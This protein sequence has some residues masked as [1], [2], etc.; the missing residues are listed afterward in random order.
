MNKDLSVKHSCETRISGWCRHRSLTALTQDRIPTP[1]GREIW[2][3][4]TVK[5]ILTN[6]VYKGDYLYQKYFMLDTLEEK[7]AT[8]QGE[9]PQYYID[10]HHE[11]IIDAEEWE[12][13]QA[14]I[15]E[16][17][18]A[19]KTRNHKKYSKNNNKNEAFIDKL[20]CGECGNG[21][22]HQRTVE[23]RGDD[24]G[25]EVHRW[26]CRLAQKYYAVDGCSSHRFQQAYLEQHFIN[27]LKD[28]HQNEG[29]QAEVNKV[30]ARTELSTQELNLEEEVRKR[31][32][33]LNQALYEAVDEELHQ[34]GQDSKRVDDLSGELVAL[35]KQLKVF[36]DRKKLA[37]QYKNE[38]KVLMK[39]VK[40]MHEEQQLVFPAE[41]YSQLVEQAT[42][43][44]DGKVVYHLSMEIDWSTDERYESSYRHQ[45]LEEKKA[46][47][48]AKR[49]EKQAEFL[50]GPEVTALL[51]YCEKPRR[52]GEILDFMNTMM[53]ISGS[54]FRKSIVLPLI[55]EGLLKRDFISNSQGKRKYY[56]VKKKCRNPLG[57][58]IQ[59]L[60]GLFCCVFRRN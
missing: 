1:Q 55:E 30:I 28:L 36:S 41:L 49:K 23:R 59:P 53:T 25:Y 54:Y 22:T 58:L 43:F 2:S 48:H 4:S 10:G 17:S 37:E 31:I 29:F 15:E 42:V 26:V 13:V 50:N 5:E 14:I 57:R 44:K 47:R 52:W 11:A 51:E 39:Q 40:K 21:F 20:K 60:G 45:L 19:F 12:A 35:H 16:R 3:L 9:L 56:M 7:V 38:S 34:D 46:R 27:M 32:E 33:Q 8:N 6:V 24:E 18:T